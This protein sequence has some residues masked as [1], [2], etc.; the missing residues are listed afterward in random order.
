MIVSSFTHI[1]LDHPA[2]IQIHSWGP[3]LESAIESAALALFNYMVPLDQ[4]SIDHDT[5]DFQSIGHDLDSMIFNFLDQLL[6]AFSTDGCVCKE[7]RVVIDGWKVKAVGYGQI[8]D[9]SKHEQ[10]TE[11]K[12]ITYSNMQVKNQDDQWDIYVI[13]DI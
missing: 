8:F 2:D 13:I 9:I 11:V 6:F 3:T 12:A 1:D 10:G 4:L 5:F 7:M